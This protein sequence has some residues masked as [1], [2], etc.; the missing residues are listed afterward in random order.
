MQPTEPLDD[1]YDK[2]TKSSHV[3]LIGTSH[4]KGLSGR[5][6]VIYV[7]AGRNFLHIS[8][9]IFGGSFSMK[10]IMMSQL[11]SWTTL[12]LLGITSTMV[13]R[14]AIGAEAKTPVKKVLK[15]VRRLPAHYGAVV[16]EKQREE[17]YRIQEEYHPKIEAIEKQLRALKKERDAKIS[18]VLTTEQRKQVEGTATKEEHKPKETPPAKATREEPAPPPAKSKPAE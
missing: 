13:E 17:I 4:K 2:E 11:A 18:A 3:G 6:T 9:S 1:R 7:A 15:G 16:D 10:R 8:F 5:I 12:V 14:S